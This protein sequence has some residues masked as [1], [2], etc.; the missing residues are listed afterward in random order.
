MR[1]LGKCWDDSPQD[2]TQLAQSVGVV[3]AT[4]LIAHGLDFSFAPVLDVDWGESGVIGE[5]ALHRNPA[6]I[7]ELGGALIAGMASAGMGSVGKHFP[8]HG[9]VRA[10][11]HLEIP[12]DDRS[13]GEIDSVDLIPFRALAKLGMSAVMPAHVVYSKVDSRAAGFS[14]IWLKDILRRQLGFDGLIFSDDLSMEG[15]STAGNVTQRAHAAFAAGCDMVLLCNDPVRTDEL[16]QGLS[17]D[18][19]VAGVDL[20]RRLQRM[21]GNPNARNEARYLAARDTVLAHSPSMPRSTVP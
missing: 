15:A 18:G 16:L 20:S 17:A 19:T 4:E 8:G 12:M 7:V 9:F 13:F 21:Y 11:S 10:D 14:T 3:I 6:A 1:T 2:A 5:R